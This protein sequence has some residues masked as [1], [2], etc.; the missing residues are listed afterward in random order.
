LSHGCP[1]YSSTEE[2]SNSFQSALQAFVTSKYI[3]VCPME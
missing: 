1:P 2:Y 3:C